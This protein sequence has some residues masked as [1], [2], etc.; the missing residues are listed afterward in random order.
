MSGKRERRNIERSMHAI[1]TT[2]GASKPPGPIVDA[3]AG[4]QQFMYLFIP[5][6]VGQ[7]GIINL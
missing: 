4:R 7:K 6:H 1:A 2:G 3:R 5:S